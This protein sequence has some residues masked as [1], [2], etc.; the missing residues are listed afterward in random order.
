MKRTL[1]SLGSIVV[2][3]IPITDAQVAPPA[4]AVIS[5]VTAAAATQRYSKTA[6]SRTFVNPIA[7]GADPWVIRHGESYYFCESEGHDGI[8]VWKSA[9]LT[10][11]GR[12]RVV[13]RSRRGTWNAREVWAPELHRIRGRWYVYYA[14]SD[15]R[16][17]N[18][19]AG[20]LRATTDDPQGPYEDMGVLYTGD[21]IAGR[22]HNRWAIDAAPFEL[23]GRLYLVWSGWPDTCDIQYLYIAPMENPWTVGGQRVKICEN[24]TH[25]WERVSERQA[26]RGL[27][28]GPTIIQRN[29]RLFVLYACSSS[30]EATYK[31]GLLYMN[32]G[33]DPLDPRSWKKL[34]RPAMQSTSEVFGLGHAS[35]TT[36]PDGTEDWIVFHAKRFREPGWQRAVWVQP[37]G[38]TKEGFPDFGSPIP[39]GRPLPVPSGEA[40]HVGG[41]DFRDSFSNET[42]DEW[43]YYGHNRYVRIREGRLEL[44]GRPGSGAVNLYRTGEK[45]IVR[46]REWSDLS[47]QVR[48]RMTAGSRDAGLVFRVSQ[49]ALGY[50]A[51]RGYFAGLIPGTRK[52]VLGRTDGAAWHELAL[53]DHP[54]EVGTWYTLGVEAV[55]ATIRVLVDGQQVISVT[56]AHHAYGQ[57]GARVVDTAAEF[58]DF[59]VK[60]R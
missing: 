3:P 27:H 31:L 34:D 16:N 44:G 35:V 19:R 21:D 55:G 10:E 38:W 20:V 24:D 41:G 43:T 25:V 36:S 48:V 26:E 2:A 47:L 14:A 46:G 42:W 37:F 13:W 32:A 45:A 57:V 58:D 28:E 17:E 29:G 23:D 59:E 60:A 9:R 30:W 49:P 56:D 18:H 1:L 39:A 4:P 33:D 22:T 12:K 8:S 7:E 6:V 40:G 52:V 5:E 53:V 15:G 11:K 50:D 54:V 51:Q